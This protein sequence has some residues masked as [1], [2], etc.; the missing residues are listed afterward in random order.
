MPYTMQETDGHYTG[1]V[2][3]TIRGDEHSGGGGHFTLILFTSGTKKE[4]SLFQKL[5]RSPLPGFVG[6]LYYLR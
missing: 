3:D 5:V 2:L 1:G 4:T 6:Q